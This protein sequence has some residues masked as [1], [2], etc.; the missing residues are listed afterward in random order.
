MEWTYYE[1]GDCDNTYKD[2]FYSNC[3]RDT[4]SSKKV[5]V[6]AMNRFGLLDVNEGKSCPPCTTGGSRYCWFALV[7]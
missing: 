6:S 1:E 4:G 2:S 5:D 3:Y 7:Q